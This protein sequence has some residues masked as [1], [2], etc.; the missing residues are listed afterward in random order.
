LIEVYEAIQI[1]ADATSPLGREE[2]DLEN[3]QGRVLAEPIRADRDSPPTDRSAMD[4]FA[5]K[6]ADLAG[7]PRTLDVIGEVPAGAPTSGVELGPGQAARIFTGG[8]I[9]P[10]ADTVVMVEQTTE[11]PQRGT[12]EIRVESER[13]SN[14]RPRGDE[15]RAADLILE[16]GTPL[17][18]P[19]LAALA[20]VGRMRCRVYR[21]PTVQVLATGDELI[22]PGRVPQDHQVRNSNSATL[23]GQLRE[24][25]IGASDLGIAPD[26]RRVL[27]DLLRQGLMGEVLLVT[28]G[29][30]VGKYD[31]V[32]QALTEAGMKLLF[33]KVAV[34]P[35]KPVMAGRRGNCL[36]IALPGNPVSAYSGFAIFVAPILR[37]LMGWRRWANQQVQATLERPLSQAPGRTTYHLARIGLERDRLVAHTVGSRGSGDLISMTRANGFVIAPANARA[38]E[39]GTELPALLWRDFEYR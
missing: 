39:A 34:K 28:G 37:R 36:V 22:E 23:L 35:G 33:H 20:S 11:D 27:D 19:E 30:S 26:D 18:P 21:Q 13:G 29:V 12:V 38:I 4:G 24:L 5:V 3:A 25:G 32:G 14:I 2:V 16:P 1:L 17:A 6:A 8:V 31:L 15:V 7:G 9:P 10:G